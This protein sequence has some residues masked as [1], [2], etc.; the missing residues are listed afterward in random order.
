MNE[1]SE[2]MQPEI[3]MAMIET[4]TLQETTSEEK[5]RRYPGTVSYADNEI[6]GKLFFGRDEEVKRLV[7]L[8]LAETLVV[9]FAKSGNGKTSLLQA[10]VFK[11]LRDRNFIPIV[12]RLNEKKQS[13][14]QIIRHKLAEFDKQPD[15][16]VL[17]GKMVNPDD[18]IEY[19]EKTEIWSKDDKLLTPVLILD[20]FE[21][22]YT[23]EHNAPY[24][25]AFFNLMAA[26]LKA[27]KESRVN[28]KIVIAI[29]E[30]F[31]GYLK[32]M[33]DIVPTAYTNLF[34]LEGLNRKY[35]DDVIA[36]P[37]SIDVK[38]VEFASEKFYYSPGALEQLKHFLCLRKE[39]GE[40]K[41]TEE[42][43]PIQLQIICSELEER[44][45]RK[46]IPEINGRIEIQEC[47]L[48]GETGLKDILGRYYDKQLN[49]LKTYL[50]LKSD[51]IIN[52]RKIIEKE[53]IAGNKRVPLAYEAIVTRRG[54]RKDAID[55]LIAAKLLRVE[56]RG[57]NSLVEISHDTLV[58]PI[59]AFC[60]KRER[61]ER[62]LKNNRNLL[63]AA[64]AVIVTIGG[65]L[66]YFLYQ[67][68]LND[69]KLIE[70]M[71][72]EALTLSTAIAKQN[73]TLA[74][75]IA[76]YGLKADSTHPGLKA[77]MEEFNNLRYA[78]ITNR[79]K[80]KGTIIFADLLNDNSYYIADDESIYRWC[81]NNI[82]DTSMNYSGYIYGYGKVN[83]NI[84]FMIW[85]D[86]NDTLKVMD[87]DNRLVTKFLV[88]SY[89]GQ[90]SVS[91]D[92]K[93]YFIGNSLYRAGQLNSIRSFGDWGS[94]Y[95][96]EK[97][98]FTKDNKYIISSHWD[99][100][101]QIHDT[102]GRSI[103]ESISHDRDANE[104]IFAFSQDSSTLI[105]GSSA[106]ELSSWKAT[107][108]FKEINIIDSITVPELLHKSSITSIAISPDN[109]YIL[110]G[111]RDKTAVLW[112]WKWEWITVLRGHTA[113]I[114]YVGFTENGN[115]MITGD[116]EGFVLTWEM[117][118]AVELNKQ[119]KLV[120]LSPFDYMEVGLSGDKY[121]FG[122]LYDTSTF[123]KKITSLLDY[124]YSMPLTNAYQ[125][126]KSY[127][128]SIEKSVAEVDSLYRDILNDK[129]FLTSSLTL[130]N[131]LAYYY[132][133][134][135][136]NRHLLLS[137]KRETSLEKQERHGK[138]Y[139]SRIAETLIDTLDVTAA[140]SISFKLK[141]IADFFLQDSLLSKQ[142]LLLYTQKR[143]DLVSAFYKKHPADSNLRLQLSNSYGYHS[144]VNI[145]TGNIKEAIIS[146]E[147]GL[148]IDSISQDWIFKD[149]SAA[150]LLDKQFKKAE[151]LYS[152]LWKLQ[153]RNNG[154]P[155]KD[156]F[157]QRLK[158]LEERGIISPEQPDVYN[159][160]KKIKE[161]LQGKRKTLN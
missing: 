118:N 71:Q 72:E 46:E 135:A 78:F 141:Q 58:E 8:I 76:T 45:I 120:K 129:R 146:S 161:F 136:L 80:A 3:E 154:L 2:K 11:K 12:I 128:K 85:K 87:K 133:I 160:A 67:Q 147:K 97:T 49:K 64:S 4:T 59:T 69:K 145:F 153:C 102:A 101:V 93:Y 57:L 103:G 66:V 28:I 31:L 119:N 26:M 75:K 137:G 149:L 110:T 56:D 43:E 107:K 98:A 7:H 36:L 50:V 111:S 25:K 48:G 52:I 158:V 127:N 22:I 54:I 139:I 15:Y 108:D 143:I 151:A 112:N 95:S 142:K 37:A 132:D 34:R 10:R 88:K 24:R 106:P 39:E 14:E 126:N 148:A 27:R 33:T 61:E 42:I 138:H 5:Q 96:I 53:L 156:I 91:P 159:E 155:F 122:Q 134:F 23:L 38:G 60:K 83:D 116:A 18:F 121:S 73:P 77:Q 113:S 19:L 100:S 29:R 104:I 40:W 150:Y 51:E 44:V 125:E 144:T 157:I 86:G 30:D 55:L 82:L 1:V 124:I 92:G 32:K 131:N 9:L 62:I 13:P 70:N 140:L 84:H 20:Q 63:L 47:D 90:A 17:T 152:R 105:I 89:P 117:G 123:D 99:K 35:I 114:T 94:W 41:E 21:E 6:S 16:E 65:I 115:K 79:I 130:R 109:K 74:L 81:P 68:I